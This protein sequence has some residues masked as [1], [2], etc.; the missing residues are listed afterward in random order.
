[1]EVKAQSETTRSGR[2][3]IKCELDQVSIADD[4]LIPLQVIV[5][6]THR[7]DATL[8]PRGHHLRDVEPGQA[9]L[10]PLASLEAVKPG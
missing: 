4:Y 6:T 2:P 3:P 8:P 9:L 7:E 10:P 1:M 5:G